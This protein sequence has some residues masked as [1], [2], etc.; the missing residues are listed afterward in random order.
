MVPGTI[1]RKPSLAPFL[2]AGP[3][4]ALFAIVLVVPMAMTVLISF[5][6][7]STMKGIEP[8][9]ILKN[10]RELFSDEYFREMFLRTLR[11]SLWVTAICAVFGAPEA[12]ILHRMAPRWRGFFLLVILGPLLI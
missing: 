7:F 12:Y 1:S 8:V 3:S 2:L 9:L 10:W 4:L 11:I 6:D 5:H